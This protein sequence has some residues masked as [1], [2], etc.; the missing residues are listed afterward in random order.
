MLVSQIANGT[1]PLR[2]GIVSVPSHVYTCHA[3]MVYNSIKDD[4]N[5]LADVCRRLQYLT[6]AVRVTPCPVPK[7]GTKLEPLWLPI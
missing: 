6:R 4:D 7:S 2:N 5:L 1:G 3:Q